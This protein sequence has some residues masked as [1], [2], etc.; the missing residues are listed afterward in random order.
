MMTELIIFV[1]INFSVT[2][3]K[4]LSICSNLF[5]LTVII[6]SADEDHGVKMIGSVTKSFDLSSTIPSPISVIRF[7]RLL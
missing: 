2:V 4:L 3:N 1:I 5:N 6:I 7:K